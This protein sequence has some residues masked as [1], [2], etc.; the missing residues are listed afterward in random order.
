M[1]FDPTSFL[2]GLGAALIVPLFSRVIRP[3]AV[4]AT[5][6][7]LALWDETRRVAAEQME[8]L[9]DIAA[10]AQA[11]RHA[12]LAE[13]NGEAAEGIV[14]DAAPVGRGRRRANGAGRR[15]PAES[16]NP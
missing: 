4:E 15:A 12:M 7:G 1:R 11:R 2:L 13:T 10:E 3:L 8:T 9:E 5:A 16:V 14:E 6:A